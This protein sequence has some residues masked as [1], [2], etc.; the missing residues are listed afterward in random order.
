MFGN[1]L[2]TEYKFI[3]S[4]TYLSKLNK[5]PCKMDKVFLLIFTMFCVRKL[6][7]KSHHLDI[8]DSLIAA[9]CIEAGI[10]LWTYNTKDFQYLLR[11][12]LL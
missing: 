8:P 12:M 9:G 10:T 4:K 2:C 6:S 3:L 5:L 11:L 1:I 7:A